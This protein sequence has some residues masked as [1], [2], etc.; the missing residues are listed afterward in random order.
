MTAECIL[1][2][3]CQRSDGEPIDLLLIVFAA[4]YL[5]DMSCR[6]LNKIWDDAC[7]LALQEEDNTFLRIRFFY[8]VFQNFYQR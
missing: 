5:S 7:F 6:I 4:T 2:R 3:F 8:S 1:S